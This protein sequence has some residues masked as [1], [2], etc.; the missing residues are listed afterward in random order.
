MPTAGQCFPHSDEKDVHSKGQLCPIFLLK[1]NYK[2]T[3][4]GN[5]E[6]SSVLLVWKEWGKPWRS[7]AY[8]H[9]HKSRRVRTSVFLQRGL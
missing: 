6:T 4:N 3:V 7:C 8:S 2:L 9:S 1:V 5:L